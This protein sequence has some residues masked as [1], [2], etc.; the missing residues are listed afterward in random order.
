MAVMLERFVRA[1]AFIGARSIRYRPE[2]SAARCCA[3]AALPPLPK[4]IN[5]P[6]D[7]NTLTNAFAMSQI[8]FGSME[9]MV[10]ELSSSSFARS[11]LNSY[12]SRS[13]VHVCRN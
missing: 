11:P 3:S 8:C 9:A 4:T 12:T 2:N 6:P 7:R 13:E 1:M 10:L 5:L